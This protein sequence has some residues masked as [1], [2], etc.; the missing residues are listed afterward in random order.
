MDILEFAIALL[1]DTLAIFI[2]TRYTRRASAQFTEKSAIHI[3][4]RGIYMTG[5]GQR[6]SLNQIK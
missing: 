3:S 2:T 5:V 1:G 4:K 6:I